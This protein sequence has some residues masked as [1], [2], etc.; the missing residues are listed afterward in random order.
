MRLFLIGSMLAGTAV[1][2][3]L[4]IWFWDLEFIWPCAPLLFIAL[5]AAEPKAS[6]Y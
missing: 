5:M 4:T 1:L 3:F 2:L 6:S